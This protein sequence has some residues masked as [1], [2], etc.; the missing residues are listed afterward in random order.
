MELCNLI[1]D[2]F[3]R[4]LSRILLICPFS[5]S[6]QNRELEKVLLTSYL[7]K[8]GGSNF[9]FIC[10]PSPRLTLELQVDNFVAIVCLNNWYIQGLF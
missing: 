8:I 3:V 4:K 1:V 2:S 7:G 6:F 5:L 10:A 9:M